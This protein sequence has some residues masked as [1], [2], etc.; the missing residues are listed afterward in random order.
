MK[1]PD[2][3]IHDEVFSRLVEEGYTVYPFLP[4]VDVAY[5][6]VVMGVTRTLPRATKSRLVGNV[7]LD[8]HVW[9][10]VENRIWVS[11]TIGAIRA[12]CG[13]I[14]DVEGR[15]WLLQESNSEIV[16]DNSTD[17][18]LYHGVLELNFKFI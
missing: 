13:Q 4:D 8:I 9:N 16:R 18:V 12:I 3:A 14:T 10:R 15:K 5:P 17:E 6:F 11:N 7:R 2:Q 1:E